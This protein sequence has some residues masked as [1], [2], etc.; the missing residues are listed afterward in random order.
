MKTTIFIIILVF[1]FACKKKEDPKPSG[2]IHI[3]V[4]QSQTKAP[5]QGYFVKILSYPSGNVIQTKT[6]GADGMA[7]FNNLD[8]TLYGVELDSS[9]GE[10]MLSAWNYDLTT[11]HTA[12]DTIYPY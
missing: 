9:N 1:S 7:I 2:S 11:N 4:G 3:F 12:I 8:Y 6:S 5:L 10:F